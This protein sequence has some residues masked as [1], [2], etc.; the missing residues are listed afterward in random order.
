MTRQEFILLVL[1]VIALVGCFSTEIVA[2][3]SSISVLSSMVAIGL[4]SL[5]NRIY[6]WFSKPMFNKK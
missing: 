5:N 1:A 2:I 3:I 6:K 4:A